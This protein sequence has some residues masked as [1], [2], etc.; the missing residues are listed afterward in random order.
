MGRPK[1]N[2]IGKRLGS[3]LIKDTA[4]SA[5]GGHAQWVCICDCGTEIILSS[6]QLR[7]AKNCG[8]TNTRV[9]NLVGRRY[10]RLLVRRHGGTD[11]YGNHFWV[12][13]CDCDKETLVRGGDLRSGSTKS[14]GCFRSE[15]SAEQGRVKHYGVENP[16]FITGFYCEKDTLDILKLKEDVRKRDNHTC[17]DCDKKQGDRALDV[18]H[19]DGDRHHNEASNMI[20]LCASCH[21][22]GIRYIQSRLL[23]AQYRLDSEIVD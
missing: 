21:H 22:K 13:I 23:T 6:P 8:C 15:T 19:I 16:N 7:F 1:I 10:G 9:E 14:C 4:E 12:C 2:L 17:Q 5:K 3:L 18:H 20:S 11:S